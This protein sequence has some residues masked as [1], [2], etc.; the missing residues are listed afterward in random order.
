M[1]I[2]GALGKL[3]I[4]I[5]NNTHSV[6]LNKFSGVLYYSLMFKEENYYEK[7]PFNISM[8]HKFKWINF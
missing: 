3:K 6:R 2:L 4:T 1:L 5:F 8:K 7:F